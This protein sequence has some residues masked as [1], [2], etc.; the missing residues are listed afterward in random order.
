MGKL[1]RATMDMYMLV[2]I[3]IL[4]VIGLVMVFSASSIELMMSGNSPY[5]IFF[6]QGRFVAAGLFV[7]LGTAFWDFRFW[8]KVAPYMYFFS[9][10]L[11]LLIFI[12][13]FGVER[14][15][16][17][18]WLQLGPIPM[19]PSEIV[20]VT[21]ILMMAKQLS[22]KSEKQ[23]GTL[24]CFATSAIYIGIPFILVLMQPSFSSGMTIL[25]IGAAV[26]MAA[27]TKVIY[28][29]GSA[30]G[31]SP[32]IY[33]Y[34][35]KHSYMMDRISASK[36]KWSVSQG[37]GFQSIQSLYA[38][39][40]GGLFGVGLG[41]STQKYQY[42]P[43]AQ[44]DF[45]FSIIGEELGLIGAVFVIGLFGFFVVRGI[46]ASLLCPDNFGRITAFGITFMIGFQAVFNIMVATGLAPTTGVS[47]PLISAGGTS[48]LIVCFALG[49]LL[50]ISRFKKA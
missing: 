26:M 15:N 3:M 47:L 23:I 10:G 27:G 50:S 20:K 48:Y 35:S 4:M 44:N 18:R 1:K 37:D 24:E 28:F 46:R 42:I 11:L 41:N 5:E 36:D 39:A 9:I 29:I 33:W 45:I 22:N 12:P 25:L 14:N 38:L 43:E 6:K 34:I 32:L 7:M 17:L 19:Q 31:V 21:L 40:N 49:I 16:A 13:G 30:L 8:K 2:S